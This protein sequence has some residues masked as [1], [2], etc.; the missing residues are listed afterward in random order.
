MSGSDLVLFAGGITVP[1]PL[2]MR[3][4]R[5]PFNSVHSVIVDGLPGSVEL[6][7]RPALLG[8]LGG[9]MSIEYHSRQPTYAGEN[10]M[11]D[12]QVLGGA[13]CYADGATLGTQ[14]DFESW[15]QARDGQA[16]I[17]ELVRRHQA[18]TWTLDDEGP[19]TPAVVDAQ[20]EAPQLP[21]GQV[22]PW[23]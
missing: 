7:I 18:T 17:D 21:A 14:G 12:C 8:T 1:A 20:P 10:P 3:L 16:I 15:F 23:A 9:G 22:S 2:S 11:S 4:W 13:T 6:Q 5:C 19:G